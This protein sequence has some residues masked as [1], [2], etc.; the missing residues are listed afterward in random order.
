MNQILPLLV[1]VPLVAAAVLAGVGRHL[2]RPVVEIGA[3]LVAA[4]TTVLAFVVLV[5]A[6]SHEAIH[7]FGG[8]RPSQG[9]ALGIAFTA[10]ALDAATAC[11]V[12]VV[13][14][15]ALGFAISYFEEAG[16]LFQVL[17]LTFL[18]GMMGFSVTGDLF[19]LFVFF[20]VMSVA[21]FAL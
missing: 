8:W 6:S 2:P 7:W 4:A 21:G 1:A 19:N 16:H 17:M 18:G 5:D 11:T 9:H 15:A 12:G 3:V 20:E 13:A 14:V 10:N